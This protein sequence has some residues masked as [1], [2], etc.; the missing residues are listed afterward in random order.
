MQ[1]EPLPACKQV[2]K[3]GFRRFLP[4]AGRGK[5]WA[6]RPWKEALETGAS[7][8]SK[9]P[10]AAPFLLESPSLLPPHPDTATPRVSHPAPRSR[11]L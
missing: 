6:Q 10:D 1:Q 5:P 7:W 9:K 4:A 11:S 2:N 3:R 8:S